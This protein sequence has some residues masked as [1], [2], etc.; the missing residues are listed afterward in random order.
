MAHEAKQSIPEEISAEEWWRLNAALANYEGSIGE[1]GKVVSAF[2]HLVCQAMASAP[3]QVLTMAQI[4]DLLR[5]QFGAYWHMGE[6]RHA[7]RELESGEYIQKITAPEENRFAVKDEL[8]DVCLREQK[9]AVT[10]RDM[11]IEQWL[12]EISGK[13]AEISDSERK[14]LAEDLLGFIVAVF[15]RHGAECAALLY[16]SEARREAFIR[17]MER[18]DLPSLP[19]RGEFNRL[20][21]SELLNFFRNAKDERAIFIGSFLRSSFFKNA[22]TIDPRFIGTISKQFEGSKVVLDTNFIFAL[23]GLRG[24]LEEDVAKAILQFNHDLGIKSIVHRISIREFR[25]ALEL[26]GRSIKSSVM[27]TRELAGAVV[28]AV[29]LKGPIGAYYKKYADTGVKWDDWIQPFLT[30]EALLEEAGIE[31]TD[32]YE[33]AIEKDPKLEEET[34]RIY[35][36]SKEYYARLHDGLTLNIEICRHDAFLRLFCIRLRKGKPH[37]FMK[38]GAWCVTLDSKL[39]RYER[40]ERHRLEDI[41]V[42][43]LTDLW[44]QYIGPMVPKTEDWNALARSLLLSPYLM[45][46]LP[47]A[48]STERIHRIAA[49]IAEYKDFKP[50]L[51]TRILLNARFQES[52]IRIDYAEFDE[53]V[54]GVIEEALL[55]EYYEKDKQLELSIEQSSALSKEIDERKKEEKRLEESQEQLKGEIKSIGQLNRITY[56]ISM[57]LLML[58]VGVS[59]DWEKLSQVPFILAVIGMIGGATSIL[60]LLLNWRTALKVFLVVATIVSLGAAILAFRTM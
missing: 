54:G 44:M 48:P 38:A 51:A 58:F 36:V 56:A 4:R 7:V 53:K 25:H 31:V 35:E 42:F 30:V 37:E 33:E 47:S 28:E 41:P 52:I 40:I 32:I 13:Y 60:G 21:N 45:V 16:Y 14:I 24:D 43:V 39:P 23:L 34:N 20:R 18:M 1:D 46:T 5:D 6:I 50:Q 59:L 2:A 26:Q 57:G 3:L 49:R 27:P 11:V 8:R 55:G 10:L 19:D 15:D 29:D 17:K 12:V 9:D 22:I